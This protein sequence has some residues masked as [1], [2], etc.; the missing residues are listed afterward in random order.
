VARHTD[1]VTLLARFGRSRRV[2]VLVVC[3]GN[4]CR[5]PYIAAVLR[6]RQPGLVI[7]SAGTAA[8]TGQPPTAGTVAA[9]ADRRLPIGPDTARPLTRRLVRDA[10]LIIT[11]TRAQ[12]VAVIG[13]NASAAERTFTLKELGRL[14]ADAGPGGITGVLAHA[15]RGL[16]IERLDHD[17]DLD[18]P[19]GQGNPAYARMAAEVDTAL[20]VIAPA[21]TTVG[22]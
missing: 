19:Y 14:L 7:A 2:D 17:D 10:R 15:A 16:L 12:R 22:A 1:Q 6:D 11:A 18:D 3:T 20:A 4:V 5:S 13:L 21:L 9:L 8:L